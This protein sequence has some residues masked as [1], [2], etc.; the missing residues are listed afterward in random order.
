MAEKERRE[1]LVLMIQ[2]GCPHCK[3]EI[4]RHREEIEKGEMVVRDLSKD[5]SA[6]RFALAVNLRYVPELLKITT[7][8]RKV[9][10]CRLSRRDMKPAQCKVIDLD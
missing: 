5:D 3:D 6:Y 2:E 8:G 10:I 4:E 1:K 9:E 7:D